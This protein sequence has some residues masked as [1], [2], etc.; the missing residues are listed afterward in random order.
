M[1]VTSEPLEAEDAETSLG[2]AVRNLDS[3]IKKGQIEI[4]DA[5]QWYTELGKFE[6]D[7]VLQGWVE[8]EDHAVKSGFDGLRTSGNTFW[9]E[10]RDW[11][12]F[13]DYEA[14][15]NNVI[16]KYRMIAIFSYSLGKCGPSEVIDVASNHQFALIRREGKWELIESSERKQAEEK[17]REQTIQNELILQTAMDGF[18]L[19]DVEG[20]ILEA[21]HA[22]SVISGYSR[23]ELVG[24]NIRDLEAVETPQET[25]KH[26]KKVMKEGCDRF[27][28]KHRH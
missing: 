8:K 27:E 5:S 10:K 20:K 9:F 25:T 7:K 24:M 1:W 19:V 6:S 21:N 13:A 18:C 11:R 26:I 23:E 16:G 17:L 4:L 22:M 14:V 28:T 12:N 15:M 3:Y 2:K